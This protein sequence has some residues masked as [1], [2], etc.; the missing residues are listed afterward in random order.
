[1]FFSETAF[2]QKHLWGWLL[3]IVLV[4]TLFEEKSGLS[5]IKQSVFLANQ[6]TIISEKWQPFFQRKPGCSLK[7][8]NLS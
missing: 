6:S 7:D 5:Q 1:M 2:D 8:T 4:C 3:V